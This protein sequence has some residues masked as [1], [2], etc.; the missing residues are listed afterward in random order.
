VDQDGSRGSRFRYPVERMNRTEGEKVS[1]GLVVD[2]DCRKNVKLVR[3]KS[4]VLTGAARNVRRPAD[5]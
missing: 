4:R 1:S 2:R 5:K 3:R